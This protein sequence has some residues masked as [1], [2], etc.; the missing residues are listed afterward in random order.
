MNPRLVSH[1]S[2]PAR[3][4]DAW[5]LIPPALASLSR[6]SAAGAVTFPASAAF[7]HFTETC[8]ETLGGQARTAPATSKAPAQAGAVLLDD[9]AVILLRA[10]AAHD[11]CTNEEAVLAALACYAK[12][13]GASVLARAVLNAREAA[14]VA[15]SHEGGALDEAGNAAVPARLND[16]GDLV[17]VP[18]FQRTGDRRF[19]SG[20][21]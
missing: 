20:G 9:H 17:D 4:A 21:P 11:A 19:R 13:I 10:I 6:A 16:E 7:C 8:P 15:G 1:T 14:S 18:E 2:R 12:A 5:G 3:I